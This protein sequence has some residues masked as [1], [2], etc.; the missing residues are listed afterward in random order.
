M[1]PLNKHVEHETFDFAAVEGCKCTLEVIDA[2]FH[3][4]IVEQGNVSWLR[5]NA[6]EAFNFV[7]GD[8]RD[9]TA[10]NQREQ[11]LVDLLID[12]HTLNVYSTIDVEYVGELL[13]VVRSSELC[14]LDILLGPEVLI[15]HFKQVFFHLSFILQIVVTLREVEHRSLWFLLLSVLC[16][17]SFFVHTFIADLDP[18]DFWFLLL[19]LCC[20]VIGRRHLR[21]T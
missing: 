18:H 10:V 8:S 1:W 11:S 4:S 20:S 21:G 5:A 16:E 6:Q 7:R 17:N 19:T 13:S 12:N 2:E 15:D 9:L 14:I 3:N